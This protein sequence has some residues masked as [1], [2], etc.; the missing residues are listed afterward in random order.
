[1]GLKTHTPDRRTGRATIQLRFNT[2]RPSDHQTVRPSDH[3]TIR[4]SDRQG[5]GGGA[6]IVDAECRARGRHQQC[7]QVRG[8]R[9]KLDM[10]ELSVWCVYVDGESTGTM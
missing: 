8:V 2:H 3:Q 4:P 6:H 7:C 1:M 9:V 5:S 10:A